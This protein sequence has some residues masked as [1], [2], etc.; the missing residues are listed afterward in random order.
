MKILISS[1][2]DLKKAAH[3]SRL[4]QFLKYLVENHEITVI[5]VNDNWKEKWD[6]KSYDYNK[7]F[8]E[9]FNNIEIIHLT[10]KGLS[11]IIQ[12]LLSPFLIRKILSNIKINDFDIHFNYNGLIFSYVISKKLQSIGINSVYDI[13]DDLPEMIRTSPQIP[14][15]IQPIGKFLGN[16]LLYKNIKSS[17]KITLTTELLGK[18]YNIPEEKTRII[19][20]G[21]DTDLFYYHNSNDLVSDLGLSDYFIVGHVGVLR[22]WIDFKPLFIAI[23]NLSSQLKVKLLIVGGGLGLDSTK[24]LAKEIGIEDS[25]VFTGTIPY[26]QIPNYI[27]CMDVGV[28]PFKEDLVSNNSLPLK[29]FE[30]MACEIPVISTNVDAIREKFYDEILFVDG[31]REYC[32]TIL[33]LYNDANLRGIYGS[34]G[35]KIVDNNY[36]WVKISKILEEVLIES[37]VKE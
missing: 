30:Y 12:E 10:N 29:L 25:V 7:D 1:I 34:N 21:V 3:N 16:Q 6:D 13:A 18:Q 33:R 22:E 5:C 28:I 11:P 9:I 23:K 26:N 20:N 17:N 19:P 24:K 36:K 31:E 8:D 4:H 37:G 14:K 27:S 35:K 15:I 2:I 32:K